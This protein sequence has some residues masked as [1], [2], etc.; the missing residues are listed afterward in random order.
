MPTQRVVAYAADTMDSLETLELTCERDEA[1]LT[2]Q[3]VKL[4]LAAIETVDGKKATAATYERIDTIKVGHLIF[5]EFAG[6]PVDE[7]SRIAIHKGKQEPHVC[8]GQAFIQNKAT[9][10]IVFREKA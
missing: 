9:N 6:T 4:Q 8:T 7:Q 3:L 2:S 10:V 5:E 1:K